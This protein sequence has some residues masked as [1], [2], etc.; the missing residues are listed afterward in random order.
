VITAISA[1]KVDAEGFAGHHHVVAGAD[2]VVAAALVHQRVGV[3][4][5]GHFGC[6][7]FSHQLD[8]VD[9]GRAISPL[10]GARQRRHALAG[11]E[12]ERV[13]RL[14]LVQRGRTGPAAAGEKAPVVQHLLQL[15]GNAGRIMRRAQVARDD[16]QLAVARAVFVGGEF[17]GVCPPV[18]CAKV[19]SQNYALLNEFT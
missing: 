10:V 6:A 13:A 18:E 7:R 12:R 17:H 15:A 14:A 2:E 11:I 16:D 9:V 19:T 3:E 1:S 4:A 5:F 8:V